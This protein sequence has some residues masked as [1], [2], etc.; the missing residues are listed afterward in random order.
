MNQQQETELLRKQ[1]FQIQQQLQDSRTAQFQLVAELSR[2]KE[3]ESIM[4]MN[5]GEFMKFLNE[6]GSDHSQVEQENVQL[7][8]E[9][10][11]LRMDLERCT[12]LLDQKEMEVRKLLRW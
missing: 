9:N 6:K 4:S 3:M 10:A 7:K 8:Q 12:E 11:R 2:K 5:P 1:T